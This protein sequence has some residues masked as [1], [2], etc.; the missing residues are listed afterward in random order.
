M[1]M[2]TDRKAMAGDCG[3]VGGGMVWKTVY[4][5]KGDLCIRQR[6]GPCLAWRQNEGRGV[7]ALIVAMKRGN[8]RGAK[9]CRKVDCGTYR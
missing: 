7:R 8:S 6:R 5:K 9:G 2:K 4:G 3:V 1:P